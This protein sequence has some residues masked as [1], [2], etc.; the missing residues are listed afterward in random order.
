MA[1]K[2]LFIWVEGD[3]DMRFFSKI[4]KPILQ[5]SYDWISDINNSPC[6]TA[7]KQSVASQLILPN[8]SQKV[9]PE[10]RQEK[11]HTH[12]AEYRLMVTLCYFVITQHFLNGWQVHDIF[13][14]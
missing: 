13:V 2:R 10:L 14:L 9:L 11:G 1:Y 6:I 3:D 8:F 5:Q 4:I 12:R 7:K